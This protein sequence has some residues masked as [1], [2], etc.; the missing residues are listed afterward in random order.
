MN[1]ALTRASAAIGTDVRG[2]HTGPMAEHIRFSPHY[3]YRRA[4]RF[5]SG[6]VGLRMEFEQRGERVL[7]NHKLGR[8][9]FPRP[10]RLA[11]QRGS[12]IM[13][14]LFRHRHHGPRWR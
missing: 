9:M 13:I 5:Q 8:S 6:E 14:A 2:R 3:F 1:A 7:F 4:R 10:R 11:P 12:A